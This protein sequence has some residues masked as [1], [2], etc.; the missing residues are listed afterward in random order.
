MDFVPLLLSGAASPIL[1]CRASLFTAVSKAAV[2][3]ALLIST[4]VYFNVRIN[5]VLLPPA[6]QP[7]TARSGYP[8]PYA[9]HAPAVL[10]CVGAILGLRPMIDVLPCV[11]VTIISGMVHLRIT[12]REHPSSWSM[13]SGM[14]LCVTWTTCLAW[15]HLE[16]QMRRRWMWSPLAKEAAEEAQQ[17]TLD[18]KALSVEFDSQFRLC[19]VSIDEGGYIHGQLMVRDD[20]HVLLVTAPWVVLNGAQFVY[21]TMMAGIGGDTVMLSSTILFVV[22][23]GLG[24]ALHSQGG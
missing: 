10:F 23:Q 6:F 16:S 11:L 1:L 2:R 21:V 17:T 15:Y 5:C 24:V 13:Y 22:L 4:T 14:H 18:V 20:Y 7:D 3:K 19:F 12:L 8:L 9:M